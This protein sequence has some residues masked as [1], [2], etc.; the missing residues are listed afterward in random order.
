[1]A[2]DTPTSLPSL[3]SALLAKRNLA[4]ESLLECKDVSVLIKIGQKLVNKGAI[5]DS[6]FKPMRDAFKSNNASEKNVDILKDLKLIVIDGYYDLIANSKS[7]ESTDNELKHL[8]PREHLVLI[9][10]NFVN[11][12]RNVSFLTDQIIMYNPKYANGFKKVV[13]RAI[14][15]Q[16]KTKR[17]AAKQEPVLEEAPSSSA[18]EHLRLP[19]SS[20]YCYRNTALQMLAA[21]PSTIQEITFKLNSQSAQG[22]TEFLA[23]LRIILKRLNNEK[24][25]EG[26]AE[27]S[28]DIAA[29]MNQ[30]NQKLQAFMSDRVTGFHVNSQEEAG[31]VVGEILKFL[32]SKS[33]FE[34]IQY[35]AES[36]E[37]ALVPHRGIPQGD[38]V[39]SCFEP[40]E[41]P[42][43]QNPKSLQD[44]ITQP[45]EH[46]I[47]LTESS[48]GSI[49]RRF[50]YSINKDASHFSLC[51][52]RDIRKPLQLYPLKQTQ[53]VDDREWSLNSFAKYTGN[54]NSGHWQSYIR[55]EAGQW[56]LVN[57]DKVS[58]LKDDEVFTEENK[59]TVVMAGYKL[60]EASSG[61]LVPRSSVGAAA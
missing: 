30:F 25:T 9:T 45:V 3:H 16:I 46:G 12:T 27:Q 17:I 50:E 36:P 7:N 43:N 42:G 40:F 26:E 1:M 48:T 32:G 49:S 8:S 14:E 44:F 4:V 41:F 60:L 35:R 19:N 55:D 5:V 18:I 13:E 21:R 11:L 52:K 22:H 58:P 23:D 53:T 6:D 31:T 37:L 57:D 33:S 56:F 10:K 2:L 38:D 54:G 29:F 24:L 59:K 51:I 47:K 28:N 61:P 34:K 20:I 39:A 15:H